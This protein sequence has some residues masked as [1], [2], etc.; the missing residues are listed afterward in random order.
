MQQHTGT[1]Q[2]LVAL[3]GKIRGYQEKEDLSDSQ[4]CQNF[5][6]LG[7]TR[8]YT[9]ILSADLDE[10][11]IEGN[12]ANYK[13]VW[14]VIELMK[15]GAAEDEPI[16]DDLSTVTDLR[17][18]VAQVMV[19]KG[20]NRYVHMQGPQGSGKT[21]AAKMLQAKYGARIVICEA[22]EI[23][24]ENM[25]AALGKILEALGVKGAAMPVAVSE[26]FNKA[27]EL[28]SKRRICLVI[29]EGHHLGPKTINLV[30]SLLNQTP[31]EFVILAM[32]TLWNRLEKTA[33]AEAWQL[34][35]NRLLERIRLEGVETSD[36]QKIVSRRLGLASDDA[37]KALAALAVDNG[38]LS[39]VKLVCRK[40]RKL[41]GKGDATTE[42]LTKA[43]QLVAASR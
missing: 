31:G 15:E 40:A 39:F 12:L 35:K 20:L 3:A 6:G 28:L 8:Q 9:R 33:Y 38:N 29:D 13:T 30:K 2:E 1:Q 7:S 34:T 16:Y 23:W 18:A 41:A 21:T 32:G 27:V 43:A 19:E 24:K 4:M 25:N 37:A 42:T 17:K 11:D 22:T 26:K 5:A 10:V 14:S 36:V